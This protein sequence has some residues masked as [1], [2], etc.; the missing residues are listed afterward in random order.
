MAELKV[1]GKLDRRAFY[2]TLFALVLPMAV[3]NLINVGVSSADVVMLGRVDEVALSAASLAGQVQFVMML[4]FFGLA[5]GASV[6]TAQYWGKGDVRTIEKVLAITLRLSMAIALLFALAAFFIPGALMRIF[7]PEEAIIEQ[8]IRYLR[9]IAPSY[10]CV[11]FTNIYLNVMRSVEKV[12]LATVVYSVSL[13]SNIVL[14]SIFIFGLL[15]APAMGAA[16]AALATTIA[17]VI[18]VCIVTVYAV[19][20]QVLRMRIKD[21]IHWNRTLFSDFIR[22]SMPATVNELLWGTAIATN[23][24][25]IGHMGSAAVAANSVAGVTRQLAMVVAFG[26]ANAAA[27]LIGKALGAG[28][29]AEA[30]EMGGKMVRMGL[31]TGLGGSVLI[32]ILRPLI[33]HLMKLGPEAADYLG[34]VLL[35]MAAYVPV[36]SLVTTMVVGVFR[37]G[38][39][40]GFGV[41]LD[42][43]GMWLTS[44]PLAAL[45]AFVL[46]WPVKW[47]FVV[48]MLDEFIKL[49]LTI[50]RYRKK[51]WLRNV[52]RDDLQDG[53][54]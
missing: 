42:L 23:A 47:V 21:Y 53:A 48:I 9:L 4:I 46:G 6:L 31:W 14:N 17:R 16:G 35:L 54:Q 29:R 12:M 52:T 24:V 33:L 40:T 10:L 38:G 25:I 34:F 20:N 5:S 7:T 36:Q 44:I 22:Y 45:A 51:I 49:P 2:K 3:Q 37:G 28:Q 11:G 39:D 43:A 18:E 50:W 27:I 41:F 15:G 30:D 32:L 1:N 8:G 19:R 13:L 26:V